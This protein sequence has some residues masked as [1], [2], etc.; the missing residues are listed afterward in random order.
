MVT[1]INGLL[2]LEESFSASMGLF[3]LFFLEIEKIVIR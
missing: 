3:F 2:D 1:C